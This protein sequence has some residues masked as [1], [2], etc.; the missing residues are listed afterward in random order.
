V[1]IDS[2]DIDPVALT[3]YSVISGSM[4]GAGPSLVVT[5]D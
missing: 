2:T 5:I 1:T 3:P 4:S